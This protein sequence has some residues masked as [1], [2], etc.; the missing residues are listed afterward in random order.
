[1]NNDPWDRKLDR[2]YVVLSFLTGYMVETADE[3]LG[4]DYFVPRSKQHVW[5]LTPELVESWKQEAIQMGVPA[6]VL[7]PPPRI[8]EL[9]NSD[10]FY[11]MAVRAQAERDRQILAEMKAEE[12]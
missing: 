12:N 5:E 10:K 3:Y 9:A 8:V 4:I 2:P 11:Q 6:V 1:M 7:E